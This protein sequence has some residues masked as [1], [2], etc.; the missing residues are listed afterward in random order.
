MSLRDVKGQEF[1]LDYLSK[2][3][4][5]GRLAHAYVFAGPRGVGKAFLARQFAKSL[6]CLAPS[7]GDS[8]DVCR[9]C[10]N[11]DGDVFP[12]V[13]TV[14][15]REDAQKVK[16]EDIKVFS[17]Y[18]VFMTPSL[19]INGEVK[20]AGNVPKDAEILKWLSS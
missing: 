7:K 14:R 10:V 12:F 8:C 15:L 11:I 19:V 20:V 16:V 3:R 1:A 13:S 6:H 2:V 9:N 17:Q 4:S 5:A 18:G